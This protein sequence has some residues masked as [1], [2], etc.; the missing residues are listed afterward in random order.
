MLVQ[1]KVPQKDHEGKKQ[2]EKDPEIKAPHEKPLMKM[3]LNSSFEAILHKN[4]S[5][6]RK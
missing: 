2:T 3:G 5:I 4:R 6:A 1:K